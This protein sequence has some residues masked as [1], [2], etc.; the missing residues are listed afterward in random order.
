MIKF[1][2]ISPKTLYFYNDLFSLRKYVLLGS[3]EEIKLISI[4]PKIEQIL[5]IKKPDY[6]LNSMV[7]DAQIGIGKVP[8]IFVRFA[9]KR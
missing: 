4:E 1:I 8:K 6:I 5:E 2:N 7:P 3:I 9:K